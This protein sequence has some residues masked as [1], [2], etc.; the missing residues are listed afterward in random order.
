MYKDKHRLHLRQKFHKKSNIKTISL[1]VTAKCNMNCSHCYAE[2]FLNI[3]PFDLED[4][5]TT[6]R[7][8]YEM[9]VFHYVLQGGEPIYDKIRLKN[10]IELIFPD[11]TYINVVSNGWDMSLDNIRWLKELQVDKICFSMDSGIEK[12]HDQGRLVGSFKKVV[13]AVQDTINEGL[14]TSISIVVTNK[15]L[16]SDGFK[17]A[18]EFAKQ[19]KIGIDVQIAE[20]VGKWDGKKELLITSR[21]AAFIKKLQKI[22]P[23]QRNGRPMVK[24][25][26]F[27]NDCDH[28][29]ACTDFMAISSNGEFLPCNFLQFSLGNIKNKSVLEMRNN[30]LKNKWFRKVYNHCILGENEEFI[31]TFII[32]YVNDKKPL[33]ANRIFNLV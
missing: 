32:P 33:D 26:I 7:E 11:E 10:I 24:R 30:A 18:Y 29:P 28:C 21:D 20:P 27:F 12:E 2:P 9:G 25:D 13:Q 6:S 5:K 17:S 8:L 15:T 23:P 22:S 1:D 16:Y 31:N 19:N 14:D 3:A 4:F